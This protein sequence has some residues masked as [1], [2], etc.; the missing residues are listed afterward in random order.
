MVENLNNLANDVA[1]LTVVMMRHVVFWCTCIK[2]LFL[3]TGYLVTDHFVPRRSN[4]GGENLT[5]KSCGL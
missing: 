5:A 3:S 2:G 4:R 1:S